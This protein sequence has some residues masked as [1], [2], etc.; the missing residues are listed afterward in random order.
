MLIEQGTTNGYHPSM[1]VGKV[2]AE[3][4][5][6]VTPKGKHHVVLYVQH[7]NQK[8]ENGKYVARSLAVYCWWY[9]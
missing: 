3:P 4:I 5:F 6:N 2:T 9:K 7:G 1:I 8:D